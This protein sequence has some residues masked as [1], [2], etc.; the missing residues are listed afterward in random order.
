MNRTLWRQVIHVDH[1]HAGNGVKLD[2]PNGS[3]GKA[4]GGTV[5]LSPNSERSM[6]HRPGIVRAIWA[7][8]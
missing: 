3:V 2:K 8:T 6:Q 5:W 7:Q 4:V 1:G